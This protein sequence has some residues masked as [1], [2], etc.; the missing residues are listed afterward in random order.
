MPQAAYRRHA[1]LA[2]LYSVFGFAGTSYLLG[3]VEFDHRRPILRV[4]LVGPWLSGQK[5]GKRARPGPTVGW[6]RAPY[7][8]LANGHK[9]SFPEAKHYPVQRFACKRLWL[10]NFQHISRKPRVAEQFP[11]QVTIRYVSRHK[12][13]RR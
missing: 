5:F 10:P 4:C 7:E 8:L 1:M 2:W 6:G 12:R 9:L 11:I 13:P 3:V